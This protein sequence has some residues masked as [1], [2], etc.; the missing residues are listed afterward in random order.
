MT[1][2]SFTTSI[3][4]DKSPDEAFRAI[5]NP[6]AWWGKTIEGRAD[7][8]GEDWTYRYKDM[9]IS[10]HK[11]IELVPGKKVVWH[12]VDGAMTFLT[13]DQHEWRGTD[14]VFD[15]ARTGDKTEIRFTHVG[16]VP[17]A[18]CFAMCAPAWTGLIQY[19]LRDLIET[20]RGA[21]DTVE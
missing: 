15:I 3:Q 20:G 10:R 6:R 18:A 8:L 2:K 19:S 9:H 5:T 21:P 14:I 13:K 17:T 7:R 11:T 4:V 1:N 12:V 16:L